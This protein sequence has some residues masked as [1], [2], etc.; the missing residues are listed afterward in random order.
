MRPED[1]LDAFV[2]DALAA[3]QA[4]DAIAR[5]IKAA[6]WSEAETRG[7]MARWA[8][9]DGPLPVPR[10]RAALGARDAFLYG[11]MFVSLGAIIGYAVTL[12]FNL[13]DAWLPDPGDRRSFGF[14]GA[15]RWSIANLVIFLPIFLL[16]DR[17]MV[18]NRI[19]DPAGGRSPM[20]AMFGHLLLFLAAAALICDAVAVLYAFL[21]GDLT[22]RFIAKAALVAVAAGLVFLYIRGVMTPE[23]A[24]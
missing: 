4:R 10:P 2:G 5:Q 18:K 19:A 15:M 7:A 3:G 1:R 22:A 24:A 12:G 9:G 17:R 16:L 11:L 6:G 23:E 21:S 20:R 8:D 14:N 13:I